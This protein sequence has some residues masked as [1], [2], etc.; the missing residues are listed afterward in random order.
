MPEDLGIGVLMERSAIKYARE[1]NIL[2]GICFGMQLAVVEFAR[3]VAKFEGAHSSEID[4]NTP[5]QL[6]T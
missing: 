1:N 4:P 3:N 5:T 6:L 2:F